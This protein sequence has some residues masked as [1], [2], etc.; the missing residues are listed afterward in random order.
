VPATVLVTGAAGGLGERLIPLV[1]ASGLRVRALV[2]ERDVEAADEQAPGDL[3]D[4]ESLERAVAGTDAV[5]HLAACTHARS[6]AEYRRVNVTGTENLL[7]AATAAQVRRFVYVSSRAV[8]VGGGG[9]SASKLAAEAT[10]AESG[11]E[12]A[13]VRLP[14]VFGAGS[15]E[16]VDQMLDA[17]R[18][19]RRL[20]VIGDGSQQL[21]PAHV[22]DVLPALVAAV[23]APDAT[24]RTYTLAGQCTTMR[25]FAER[26]VAATGGRSRIVR[27][28]VAA[29]RGL[30]FAARFVPLP[31]YPDQLARLTAPKPPPS[32]E[33]GTDL[34]FRPRPLDDAIRTLAA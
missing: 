24:G 18:A 6:D 10:V 25:D 8:G 16:G 3:L 11:L 31:L 29:V 23:D 21:C 13:I 28:P 34:G 9:Y 12:F 7:R 1:R 32:R 5:L 22:D 4:R 15:R 17:A 30:G 20:V 26:V 14:E 2:H 19:G 27:V 33:A